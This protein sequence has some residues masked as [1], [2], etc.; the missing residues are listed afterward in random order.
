M[1]MLPL[2]CITKTR[3][4]LYPLLLSSSFSS[5]VPY[6][7]FLSPASASIPS[8][9]ANCEPKEV[10]FSFKNWFKSGKNPLI[11]R[12]FEILSSTDDEDLSSRR[13]ADSALS[14]LGLRLS[15]PFVLEVLKY[16]NDVLSCLKF[17]DWAGRQSGFYHTRATFNA[18]LKILSRAKLMS[19][20]LDFLDSHL[21]LISVHKVRFYNTLVMGYAVAGK[22]DVALQLFGKMR[23]H[24]QDLDPFAYHVLLNA[25]VEANCFDVAKV[26][27]MQIK[28]R[29]CENEVTH[30]IVMK[31]LCKQNQLTEAEQYLRELLSG[32]R[33]VIGH[34][35]SV[36]VDAFC[37]NNKFEHASKLIREIRETGKVPMEK[38]Y[39]VWIRSLVQA[40]KLD[41]ALEFLQTV[42]SLEGY[43]PD[44]FRYNILL[45]TLLRK[46]RL[47]DVYDLL[48]EM[49]EFQIV[50]DK[51]TMNTALCFFCKAGMVEVALELYNSRSE[52]GLTPNSMAY[53]YL[54]NTLCGDGSID[55]AYYILKNSIDEGYFPG[56]KTFSILADA[57]C[58]E[59]K[60]DKMKELV[61]YALER[62][63]FPSSSIYDKFISALCRARRVEDGYLI[64]G[65]L[66][67]LNNVSSRVTYI[68][69]INGF[70][71]SNR[72]DISARLLLE[73]Q[74]KGH[75]PNRRLFRAVICSLCEMENPE[76]QFLQLLDMQLSRHNPETRIYN[77][78][79]DGAGHA[80]RPDLAREVFEMMV[81]SGI[82]TNLSSDILILQSYLK[83]ERISDALNFFH[84]IS[85]RRKIR[86]KLYNSMVVGLCKAKKSD[87]A[88]AM[89]RGCRENGLIPSLES[90]EE[91]ILLLSSEKKYDMVITLINDMEKVGRRVSSFIGNVLLLHSLKSRDL[92]ECWVRSRDAYLE[93]PSSSMLGQ[94]IAAFSAQIRADLQ[95]EDLEDAIQQCFPL[96]LYSYNMLLRRLSVDR[97]DGA[98]EMF[99]R[100][101]QKGYEP[102]RWTYHILMHGLYR[103]GR[104]AEAKRWAEEMFHRGFDPEERIFL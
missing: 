62:N 64:H 68:D 40:G 75:S 70:N 92:Y 52:F 47:K 74:E 10:A 49:K 80:K 79:I 95:V 85:K 12:I 90:Y 63:F 56:R 30:S 27:L 16:K 82:S 94:L 54:I 38:S 89:L 44:V 84:D 87:I 96:D 67:R 100:L 99:H 17:F 28:M 93:T 31:S 65:E 35:F 50:P 98:C 88:L 41:N 86:R 78:F 34:V 60:L 91:L 23:F 58:Q 57:L 69:M 102:N 6:P 18:I 104:T 73:M 83:S 22:P 81:R 48:T 37:T 72:G 32:G 25:L 61:I 45:S 5:A 7:S 14:Q 42:K 33:V 24:G 46:N 101:C 15:E 103:H 4:F 29:D 19:L 43:I 76:K 8:D 53:N 1:L 71:K 9:F 11:E 66:N 97:I 21:K 13:T 26:V 77:F 36:L 3:A 55:E 39:A 2:K 51:V 20:M 59:H